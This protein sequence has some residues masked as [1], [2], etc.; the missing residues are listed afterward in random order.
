MTLHS[1]NIGG[2]EIQ[3]LNLYESLKKHNI[4]VIILH[5]HVPS[6]FICP[7]IKNIETFYIPPFFYKFRLIP[8][9]LSYLFHFKIKRLPTLF[10]CHG[11]SYFTE[12]ILWFA[13]KKKIPSLIKV[14]TENHV[15]SLK[16]QIRQRPTPIHFCKKMFS[17]A[18]FS[19]KRYSLE[20]LLFGKRRFETYSKAAGYLSINTNI[21]IELKNFP[22]EAS[23]IIPIH[24]A[25]DPK[26]FC[27]VTEPEKKDLKRLLHLPEDVRFITT[28]ARFV[29][30]KRIEDLIAAWARIAKKF[31]QHK[32]LLV[33]DGPKR[34]FYE[35]LVLQLGIQSQTLFIG[36]HL[37]IEKIF[38]L[39]DL[40]AFCSEREGLPNVLLEAMSCQLPIV[41][42]AISG[43]TEILTSS[44]EGLLFAPKDVNGLTEKLLY[45]LEHPEE[46]GRMALAAREKV[47]K[48]YSFEKTTPKF[49]SIYSSL[50]SV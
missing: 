30:R 26:R 17:K 28:V 21:G 15:L 5:S 12:Q 31:P 46:A 19:E 6:G 39:S 13:H 40:F 29:E 37:Q 23:K 14:T 25:V 33:G 7:S 49:L 41:A 24:N 47:L 36:F 16:E 3:L 1:F 10:H 43:V 45:A 35:D 18:P 32:L 34:G 48:T 20:R 42:S 2:C 27:P 22:I 50:C 8:L 9:Y 44:Q 38:Q 11:I 4:N